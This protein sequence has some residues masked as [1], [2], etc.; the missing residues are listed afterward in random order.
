MYHLADSTPVRIRPV[1][2]RRSRL[3]P[4]LPPTSLVLV[5][6]RHRDYFLSVGLL[7]VHS[8]KLVVLVETGTWML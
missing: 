1:D 5:E 3:R 2:K 8:R 7:L 4:A 6:H